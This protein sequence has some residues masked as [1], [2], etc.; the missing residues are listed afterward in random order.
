MRGLTLLMLLAISAIHA[1]P[2][3]TY[4]LRNVGGVNYV[5]SVKDQQGGTCWTHG[6]MASIE[7]NLL[8][9][10]AWTVAG[11]TGEPNLAEYHL[12]WWNGFNEWNNDDL[13]PPNGS[14]LVV[15]EGGDYMVTTAYLSRGEGAVRDIDGQSFSVAPAR[16][17][18]SYRY[19]YPRQ[20]WWLTAEADLSNIDAIKEAVMTY[21]V[22]GT[23]M[24]YNSSYISNYIHY[25]P[26]SSTELPNHAVA[27]I[28][29]DDNLVTQAP[30]P[31]AWLV[32]NSWGTSWGNSGYFW[33][34]YYDKYS[35]QEPQM[36]AV[37]FQQVEAMRYDTIYYHDYHGWR[38]TKT[39]CSEAFNVFVAKGDQMIQSASF[40]AA[41]DSAQY[42]VRIYGGFDGSQ[43]TQLLDEETGVCERKGFYTVDFDSAPSFNEGDTFYL[44]LYLSEGGQPYDRTSD[45]PVLLGAVYRTIVQ[46]T[47][48]P[49]E[50]YYKDGSVW[51][52]LYNWSGN[53][54]PQ[55]GN[56]CIKACAVNVGLKVSP[57]EDGRSQG[58]PGGPFTPD[59]FEYEITYSGSDQVNYSVSLVNSA[60]W[61]TLS[62]PLTGSLSG[63][64]T[65]DIT[66]SINSNANSL[67]LGAYRATV[68]FQNTTNQLGTTERDIILLVGSNQTV[69]FWSL[70]TNPGW[71]CDPQWAFGIP[72]GQGGQHGN[73]D[74]T[75]GNTG[76]NVFGY[77]LNGDYANNLSEKYLTT[78]AIDLSGLYNTELKFY[79]WLGV[80]ASSYDHASLQIKIAN[81]DWMTIWSNPDS[82]TEDNSWTQYS[83]D[84]SNYADN[85]NEVYLRWVMGTTDGGWVYCGWNI[86]DIEILG[87]H[88]TGVEENPG[89]E[90]PF[91][92]SFYL[93]RPVGQETDILFSLPTDQNIELSV[94]DISGRK[95]VTLIDEM[96][97]AGSYSVKWAG[98]DDFG[99]LIADGVYFVRVATS[100][101]SVSRKMVLTR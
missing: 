82:H 12:D 1:D 23:C 98:M 61:L 26:P 35:C 66:F 96:K 53:P 11:D 38:D 75:S 86:D 93:S 87:I 78:D 92:L 16:R 37:S 27:I 13:N 17:L 89:S 90:I 97:T 49:G 79:R 85:Q 64:D 52:D 6:A 21:G 55:T 46:S 91:N 39:D 84:I 54:Y 56:F 24:C 25:Q 48:H 9:T 62:G 2:P 3:A 33:I 14:G 60:P 81:G 28:G 63:S 36:G 43:L 32:K 77:N 83:Y 18:S 29:W 94:F 31:G 101:G 72:T 57:Q 42:T 20:V 74:P 65:V 44:Y 41:Q 51:N 80:E 50:S 5:T 19:Y 45:V 40:F 58:L 99:N 34:S 47:A 4:D 8:M 30:L 100:E 15:H 22:L 69:Y 76:S 71:S 7:G 73:P 70:D 59:Q 10:G 68:Q 67:G 95:V 88:C